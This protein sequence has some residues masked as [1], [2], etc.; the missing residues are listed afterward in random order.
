ME[1][2]GDSHEQVLSFTT[3]V[4]EIELR[5]CGFNENSLPRVTPAIHISTPILSSISALCSEMVTEEDFLILLINWLSEV[6]GTNKV[7]SLLMQNQVHLLHW[8]TFV[9]RALSQGNDHYTIQGERDLESRSSAI[10]SGTSSWTTRHPQ[11]SSLHVLTV[12]SHI[13]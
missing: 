6:K 9:S 12:G 2:R 4:S 8:V 3:W 5:S 7:A 1:I 13:L 11:F 10:I